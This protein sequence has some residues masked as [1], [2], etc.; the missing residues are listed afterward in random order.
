MH[1]RRKKPVSLFFTILM[2]LTL[3]CLSNSLGADSFSTAD[4]LRISVNGTLDWERKE[5]AASTEL[6][7]NSAGIRSPLGRSQAEEILR[8]E[9][10]GLIKSLLFSLQVD[11][12]S[13]IEDLIERGELSLRELDAIYSRAHRRPPNFS[14]DLT[15]FSG[16][17]T[18]DLNNV[19]ASLSRHEWPSSIEMPLFPLPTTDYTGI[20]IIADSVLPVHGRNTSSLVQPCIF[21]KIW[22][23]DMNLIFERNITDPSITA[24]GQEM[25][26]R[27]SRNENIFRPTP[28]GI[29]NE[30]IGITGERPLKIFARSVF[31][32]VPTDP[33]IDRA[34]AMLILSSENNRRLL[35][36]GRVVII[37]NDEVLRVDK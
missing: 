27:Y 3:F 10:P 20:I 29:D 18:I 17:Y 11:S 33:I 30:L 1:I 32:A 34:D 9:Y 23:T 4:G 36:E 12:F 26:V 14:L 19:S 22:D 8:E 21:P 24:S 35:R 6:H 25:I 31:G 37:L 16:S 2:F 15:R 7:L 5:L 28:S 13:T